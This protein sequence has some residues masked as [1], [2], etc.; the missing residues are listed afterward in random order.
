MSYTSEGT[1]V[2]GRRGRME[3][4]AILRRSVS[5]AYVAEDISCLLNGQTIVR[6]IHDQITYEDLVSSD[7][8]ALYSLMA[9]TGYLRIIPDEGSSFSVSVPNSGVMEVLRSIPDGNNQAQS[10]ASHVR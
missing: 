10:R 3:L 9:M 5:D 8:C 7:E 6:Y 2:G 4:G 1:E